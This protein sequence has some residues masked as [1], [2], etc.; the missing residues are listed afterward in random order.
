MPRPIDIDVPDLTGK[1]ALVTGGSD[2]VGRHIAARLARAGADVLLPVR[3]QSKGEATI[4]WVREQTPNGSIELADLDLSSQSSVRD[5]SNELVTAGQPLHILAHR[6]SRSASSVSNFSVAAKLRGGGSPATCPTQGL[7]R[8]VCCRLARK[9][10]ATATR[11]LCGR[12]G[13]S[14]GSGSPA[15]LS[16]QHSR[17][18]TRQP[19][20]RRVRSHVRAPPDRP[21]RWAPSRAGAVL[22]VDRSG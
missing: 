18:S 20:R 1:R 12:S 4:G 6:K 9:S 15:R 8:P 19:T 3:N 16:R 21:H 5:L 13:C 11:W 14:P 10:D 7:S 22:A 2:G 17:R